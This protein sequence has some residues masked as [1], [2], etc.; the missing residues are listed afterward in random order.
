MLFRSNTAITCAPHT[1]SPWCAGGGV[2]LSLRD[3]HKWP[4]SVH[5]H[6]RAHSANCLCGSLQVDMSNAP[7]GP[8]T[9]MRAITSTLAARSAP[10]IPPATQTYEPLV[11]SVIGRRLFFK[12]LAPSLAYSWALANVWSKWSQ[13]GL[14]QLGIWGSLVDCVKP[15]T[16]LH[17]VAI[18]LLGV[19]PALVIRNRFITGESCLHRAQVLR[20]FRLVT[21]IHDRAL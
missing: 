8:S 13:G 7:P 14:S 10:T 5:R 1:R 15:L 2:Q 17:A 12:I 19:I 3:R 11:K 9:P 6:V 20:P 4:S 16:L 21:R 18:W